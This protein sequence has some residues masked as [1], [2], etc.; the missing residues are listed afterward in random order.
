MKV[1]MLPFSVLLSALALACAPAVA[2]DS[3]Q[4]GPWES[5]STW[6]GG[7]PGSHP[8]I[9]AGHTVTLTSAT[10]PLQT[11]T[12]EDA[13]S[14]NPG[15]L[16]LE[17]DAELRVS[18]SVTVEFAQAV[19]GVLRFNAS[20]GN[21][22]A[23]KAVDL[24]TILE[25]D[26]PFTVS[27]SLGG[28]LI[29]SGGG[30]TF[31][32]L[33]GGLITAQ[34]GPMTIIAKLINNGVIR[35][36][37]SSTSNFIKFFVAPGTNS[38]GLFEVSGHANARMI[39]QWAGNVTITAGADILITDGQLKLLKPD[40]VTIVRLETNGGL[41]MSSVGGSSPKVVVDSDGDG[42]HCYL[43]ATGTFNSDS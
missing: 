19:S 13:A 8:V 41:K 16:S 39:F 15:I 34:N 43:K 11:V 12:I 3:A 5:S 1:R 9:K 35:A 42:V 25:L 22:P 24:F 23:I 37:A 4:S 32:L 26:G 30:E 2:N 20:S 36:S 21:A 14:G 10:G 18:A 40:S 27:S 17:D 6:V 38:S 7:T 31:K 28:N 29:D 33:S